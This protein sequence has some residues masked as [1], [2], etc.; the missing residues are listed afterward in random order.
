MFLSIQTSGQSGL[1]PTIGM[2]SML[3]VSTGVMAMKYRIPLNGTDVM[4][5]GGSDC[6]GKRRACA[7]SWAAPGRDNTRA[8]SRTSAARDAK[9]VLII[10]G[11]DVT[12]IPLLDDPV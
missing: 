3:L 1:R 10:G 11:A 7:V 2:W 4:T 5:R 9:C 6:P 8:P 12:R